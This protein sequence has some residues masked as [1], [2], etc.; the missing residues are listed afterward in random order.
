MERRIN[1]LNWLIGGAQ[2]SGVDSAAGMFARA[3]AMGGL[4][5]YGQREYYSNIMGEHSY[6]QVRVS[7][8]PIQATSDQTYLLAT[9]DAETVFLHARS[10]V[11]QGGIIYDPKLADTTLERLP[12]MDHR[13]REDMAQYLSE[14]G[15]GDSLQDLLNLQEKRGVKLYPVPYDELLQRLSEE[16]GQPLSQLKRTAN[17]MAVAAS[18]AILHYGLEWLEKALGDVFKEKKRVIELNI[19]ACEM[20]YEHIPPRHTASD[21][22]RRYV[23]RARMQ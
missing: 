1:R 9:F 22:Q 12:T 16:L 11:S 13:A 2:G 3:C 5:I 19:R 14:S 17:T 8:E 10:V 7:E 23:T 21:S 6:F 20:V 4:H 15:A 18:C